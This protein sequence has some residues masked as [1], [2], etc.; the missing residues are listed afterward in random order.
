MKQIL[1]IATLMSISNSLCHDLHDQSN[2]TSLIGCNYNLLMSIA[3]HPVY[4]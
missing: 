2:A 1:T 4:L 3:I